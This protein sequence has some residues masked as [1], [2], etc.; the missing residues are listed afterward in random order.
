[1]GVAEPTAVDAVIRDSAGMMRRTLGATV[2]LRLDLATEDAST[3]IDSHQFETALLN[4]VI[5]A[6][7]AMPNGGELTIET[8]NTTIDTVAAGSLKG[9]E[10]GD[11]LRV[12]VRDTGT[13]MTDE[14]AQNAFEPFFT[15]K[16]LSTG[17]GLGLSMVYS[18][19]TQF[20]G[21]VSIDSKWGE[22]TSVTLLLPRLDEV[23]RALEAPTPAPTDVAARILV[24]EDDAALR[25]LVI[26]MLE[27][28]GYE[29]VAAENGREALDLL[30]H[31]A[32]IDLLFT[33]VVLPGGINGFEIGRE[34]SQIRG[35]IKIL[36]T[37]GYASETPT[38]DD[39][40]AKLPIVYKPYHRAQLLTTIEEV[41][42]GSWSVGKSSALAPRS[43][44]SGRDF[45]S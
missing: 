13:G 23:P 11:Y 28:R 40:L 45:N 42:A 6:R 4:L 3:L 21:H 9:L 37:S 16:S 26:G 25:A 17:T 27:G 12:M 29:V 33:D 15:T 1:M 10:P 36:L 2:T 30:R 19:V 5:N 44:M 7:D 31:D 39:P 22:G 41:L 18:F 34:A 8:A 35:D 32:K 24:V 20:G 43:S 38:E 14:I